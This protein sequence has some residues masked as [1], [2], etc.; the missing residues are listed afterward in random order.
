VCEAPIEYAPPV[1][2]YQG[3]MFVNVARLTDTT[4]ARLRKQQKYLV[5]TDTMCTL[6]VIPRTA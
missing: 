4:I 1:F 3:H 2:L 5:D 6:F